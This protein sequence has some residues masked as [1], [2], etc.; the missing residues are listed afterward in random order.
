MLIKLLRAPAAGR[1]P[2]KAERIAEG[3]PF[4]FNLY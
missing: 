3:D 4:C 1:G 2:Q